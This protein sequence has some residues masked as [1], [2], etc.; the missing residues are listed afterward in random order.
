MLTL[1]GVECAGVPRGVIR[2]PADAIRRNI[3][4]DDVTL[5][6]M[7]ALVGVVLFALFFSTYRS[8]R[9][10][11]SFCWTNSLGFLIVGSAAYL[12]I[13][14]SQQAWAVPLGNALTIVGLEWAWGAARSL[15]AKTLPIWLLIVPGLIVGLACA[16]DNPAQKAAQAGAPALFAAVAIVTALVGWEIYFIDAQYRQVRFS[17]LVTSGLLSGLYVI[18]FIA[19]LANDFGSPFVTAVVSE[20]TTTLITVVMLVTVS[21]SMAELSHDEIT[22]RLQAGAS[23]SR[24]LL[25]E[26]AL[27]QQNLL[28]RR[29]LEHTDYP[30]AGI[31]VP[32]QA[33]SGDFFDWEET[34]EGLIITVGD[35][36]GKGVGAA[37]LGATIRAGLR[38]AQMGDPRKTVIAVMDSLG[39]DLVINDSYL[40]LFHAYLDQETGELTVLDAGHGLAVIVRRDGRHERIR[41]TN[42]PLGLGPYED[43]EVLTVILEEGDRLVVFSD[44]VL[45]LF[46]GSLASLNRA[47]SLV[48]PP[49][50]VL[51]LS[52][53]VDRMAALARAGDQEDDVT[54]VVVERLVASARMPLIVRTSP[55]V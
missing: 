26:G 35:V 48:A 22:R 49:G 7:F 41:S 1:R 29:P 12:L 4:L 42:L 28:P 50:E 8:S 45:D 21:F 6:V 19:F 11:Y 39:N 52:D 14:T 24:R 3:I 37:M 36:M 20:T 38:I 16:L 2:L 9:S 46:D 17:L 13:G 25:S 33:L 31:C 5:R 55:L 53:A 18:R 47:V 23:R 32:S 51:D 40:T 54:V 10:A 27:V 15:R 30:I 44:G 34:E 43:W